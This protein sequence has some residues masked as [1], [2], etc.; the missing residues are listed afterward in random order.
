MRLGSSIYQNSK[1]KSIEI[2]NGQ[3]SNYGSTKFASLEE[4]LSFLPAT[5]IDFL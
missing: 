4:A 1:V 2:I 3:K 5:N